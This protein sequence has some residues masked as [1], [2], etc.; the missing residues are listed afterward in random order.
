MT[1]ESE[2]LSPS[3]FADGLFHAE[4]VFNLKSYALFSAINITFA[5]ILCIIKKANYHFRTLFAMKRI[6]LISC[7]KQKKSV[8]L[9]AKLLYTSPLFTAAST[10]ASTLSFENYILSAKYGLVAPNQEIIPYDERLNNLSK[11]E[12]YAWAERVSL[13]ITARHPCPGEVI[14][15]AGSQYSTYLGNLLEEKFWR[16]SEPLRGLSQGHRL[17]WLKKANDLGSHALSLERFYEL[18]TRLLDQQN[19]GKGYVLGTDLATANLP[20]R[21]VYFF[22]E[23]TQRRY[24]RSSLR[25]TRVGTHAISMGS[26]SSLRARL[27]THRGTNNGQGSHRS[28]VFRRHIGEALIQQRDLANTYPTWNMGQSAD[29]ETRKTESFLESL[30]SQELSKYR[31]AVLPVLDDPSANSDR[32]YIERNSIALL[33]KI[34]RILDPSQEWLGNLSPTAEIRQSGL[35]NVNHVNDEYTPSFLDT[36]EKLIKLDAEGM[37][38]TTSYAPADWRSNLT[39]T[40]Q[41]KLIND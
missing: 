21:G 40:Q 6:I 24:G 10:F 38:H 36:L 28:S 19:N 1:V 27:R 37:Y 12:Q 20:L 7:S 33:S 30:V 2:F 13:D 22:F 16:V 34:G 8:P 14:I 4:G 25:V 11:T 39:N 26:S 31:F 17:S 5:I 29:S 9:P 15:L 32:A 35:W 18:L 41:L 23:Q 3:A